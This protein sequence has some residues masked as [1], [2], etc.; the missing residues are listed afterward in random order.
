MRTSRKVLLPG[1][2]T[3]WYTTSVSAAKFCMLLDNAI[4][5]HTLRAILVPSFVSFHVHD[6]CLHLSKR[7]Y[8]NVAVKTTDKTCTDKKKRTKSARTVKCH[9]D[10]IVKTYSFAF[11]IWA[12][13]L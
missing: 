9:G 5:I 10:M 3:L 8:N 11:H 4:C 12:L 2:V 13:S 1:I 7:L 6:I